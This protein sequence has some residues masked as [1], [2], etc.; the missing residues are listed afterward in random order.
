MHVKKRVSAPSPV[1]G[2]HSQ[3]ADGSWW[4]VSEP[5]ARPQMFGAKGDG[6]NDDTMAI[7]AAIGYGKEV[8]LPKGDYKVTKTLLIT[9]TAQKISGAGMG[10]GYGRPNFVFTD[11]K[12]VTRIIGEGTFPKRIMT[13]CKHRSSAASPK[14]DT[15]S[16]I[17]DVEADSVSISDLSL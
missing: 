9:T 2:W 8:Y 10:Y 3:S 13:R 14:D 17:I 7:Q 12:P 5:I 4:E 11:F 15:M 1:K 6:N 16:A